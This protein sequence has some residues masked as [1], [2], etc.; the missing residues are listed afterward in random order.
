L[1]AIPLSSRGSVIWGQKEEVMAKCEN[2]EH[3]TLFEKRLDVSPSLSEFFR[4][5][6]CQDDY[7]HCARHMLGD[8]L[9]KGFHL[10]LEDP[11]IGKVEVFY[12]NLFPN[13]RRK[14]LEVIKK[15]VA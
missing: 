5:T 11:A 7:I 10:P 14:A 8:K 9:A 3:C 1:F 6:Y 2:A 13:E 12:D 15:L 4:I